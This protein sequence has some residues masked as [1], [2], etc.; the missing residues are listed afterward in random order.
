MANPATANVEPL[1]VNFWPDVLTKPVAAGT[2][3]VGVVEVAVVDL[4]MV[5]EVAVSGWHCK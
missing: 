3:V 1:R 2:E 5:V 4:V